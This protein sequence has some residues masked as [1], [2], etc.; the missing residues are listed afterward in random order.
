[1]RANSLSLLRVV[2]LFVFLALT[3]HLTFHDLSTP[4]RLYAEENVPDAP[5]SISGVVRNEASLPI[6]IAAGQTANTIDIIWGP[7]QELY[8]PFVVR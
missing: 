3:F 1:M 2:L 6:D 5:G 8:L 4:Q 7:D